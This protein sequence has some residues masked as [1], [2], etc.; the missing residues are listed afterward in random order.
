MIL[1]KTLKNIKEVKL[2][3]SYDQN[4]TYTFAFAMQKVCNLS[5]THCSKNWSCFRGWDKDKINW[6]P[7]NLCGNESEFL[8]RKVSL[9]FF[10]FVAP[11][12]RFI[13]CFNTVLTAS[14]KSLLSHTAEQI[15]NKLLLGS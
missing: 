13:S 9:K 1:S 11:K 5:M 8:F 15:K 3:V 12:R 7:D 14:G 10:G 6:L 4:V 2:S